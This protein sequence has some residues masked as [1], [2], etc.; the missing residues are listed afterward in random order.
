MVDGVP[1]IGK[2]SDMKDLYGEYRY[3]VVAIG[4]NALRQRIYEKASGIGYG[5]PN[6]LA[7]NVYISPYA[8]VGKGCVVLNNAVIQ[9]NSAL[10]DG[11]ILNPGVELHHGSKVGSCS[12]I[13]TNSVIR[14]G[15]VVG[16]RAKI[17]STL[18]I[19]NN[20]IIKDDAVIEDG[21]SVI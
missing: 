2:I 6:I 7:E 11:S 10:G 5:F 1:V 19:G 21:H 4:N 9:N 13:Y 17:G 16:D 3:L 18:T 8:S 20:V 15:A 14:S 12:L